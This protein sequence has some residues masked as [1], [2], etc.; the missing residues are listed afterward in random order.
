MY[1]LDKA[2]GDWTSSERVLVEE[3]RYNATIRIRVGNWLGSRV[4]P[5]TRTSLQRN[6]AV[7]ATHLYFSTV[8]ARVSLWSRAR[9]ISGELTPG[10][11][12]VRGKLCVSDS[13]TWASSNTSTNLLFRQKIYSPR[14]HEFVQAIR[15]VA[16]QPNRSSRSSPSTPLYLVC[17]V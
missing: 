8:P 4:D 9:G 12:H 10:T 15:Y 7:V 6:R 5:F 3:G 17:D 13:A 1:N 14:R 16:N 11:H 2:Y